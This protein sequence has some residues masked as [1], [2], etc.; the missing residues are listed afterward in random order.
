MVHSLSKG[1]DIPFVLAKGNC[2]SSFVSIFGINLDL[3]KSGFHIKLR[4]YEC[5][6]QFLQQIFFVGDWIS[7]PFLKQNLKVCN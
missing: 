2:K 4:K 1:H 5:R 3:P 6:M 7:D